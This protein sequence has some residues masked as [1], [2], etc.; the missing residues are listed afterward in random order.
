MHEHHFLLDMHPVYPTMSPT[1]SDRAAVKQI[2]SS[3]LSVLVDSSGG[4]IET[5]AIVPVWDV[6]VW[7]FYFLF[8]NS[9]VY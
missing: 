6:M 8:K 5:Y 9:P 7:H 3:L 1:V 4:T 2:R